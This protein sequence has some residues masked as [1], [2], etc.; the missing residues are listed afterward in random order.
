MA[1][2][3]MSAGGQRGLG[4][5]EEQEKDR[6]SLGPLRTAGHAHSVGLILVDLVASGPGEVQ[7]TP[8]RWGW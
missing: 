6:H 3:G 5:T 2:T 8:W 4:I 7:C 1:A